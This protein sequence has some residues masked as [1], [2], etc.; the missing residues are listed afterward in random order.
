MSFVEDVKNGK[1]EYCWTDLRIVSGEL[2]ATFRVFCDALKIGGVRVN[3]SAKDAQLIADELGA[4]LPTAKLLDARYLSASIDAEPQPK[5]YEGGV[6]MDTQ[7]A[8]I[9]HNE[10]VMSA[11]GE[12]RAGI[13]QNVGK[14]WVL[15]RRATLTRSVLYGWHVDSE[16]VTWKGIKLHHAVTPGLRVIQPVSTAHDYHHKDY[17]MTL[18]LLHGECIVNGKTMATEEVLTTAELSQLLLHDGLPLSSGRLPIGDEPEEAEPDV[19]DPH[20]TPPTIRKGDRGTWVA[21]WQHVLIT[22]GL[23][24]SPYGADGQFGAS[25][26][27]HTKAWQQ[28]EGLV[29]DG[30]VGPATWAKSGEDGREPKSYTQVKLFGGLPKHPAFGPMMSSDRDRVFGHL[31]YMSVSVPG[32]P[33]AIRIT[34]GW[35]SNVTSVHIPQLK[36]VLGAP[37]HCRITWHKKGAKQLKQLWEA[38]EE[39]GLLN[40]VISWAGSWNPRFIRGSRRTLSNHAYA[41]AFDINSPDNPL[42]AKPKLSGTGSV[43]ELVT[44]ANDLGF[45]WGGHY[46]SRPDGMH[47]EL[48]KILDE[49]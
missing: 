49:S 6:G 47:F 42:G 38:W 23:D 7:V 15:D 33:E 45:Y 9:E 43:L 25:T 3:V 44:I 17:S 35:D 28:A 24:L 16:D 29:A 46:H 30:I 11:V 41:T 32:N 14:H 4:H 19:I 1:A 37:S 36:S 10:R 34:N 2:D 8:C 13:V 40:R 26:K 18:L 12:A 20:V 31:E 27:E 48:A 22:D 39:E 5:Y 21:T